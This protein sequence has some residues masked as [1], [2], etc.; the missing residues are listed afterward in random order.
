MLRSMLCL[1]R[2]DH[3]YPADGMDI[4]SERPKPK[5]AISELIAL[6]QQANEREEELNDKVDYWHRKYN[7]LYADYIALKYDDLCLTCQKVQD[8]TPS[9]KTYTL[10]ESC[11]AGR[12]TI[13]SLQRELK[14]ERQDSIYWQEC[15]ETALK[16]LSECDYTL[17]QQ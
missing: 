11:A 5:N 2:D 1:G 10:C 7:Q 12:Q 8:S 14:K 15:Y 4:V 6:F 13:E 9:G 3:G 16:E 17:S